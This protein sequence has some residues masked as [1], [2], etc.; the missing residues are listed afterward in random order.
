LRSE[1]DGVRLF[2]PH[3][4]ETPFP[5]VLAPLTSLRF[6]L[7]LGVVLF[8][9]QLQWTLGPDAAGL[10]NRARL[11]VDAFF[12]LSGFILTHV[13]LQGETAPSYFACLGARVARVFPVHWAILGGL[14]L[15]IL[16]APMVGVGLEPD[17]FNA[18]DFFTTLILVQ[19]WFPTDGMALWNGPA[20]SLSAEWFAYLIFPAFAW[21]AL[22]LK[23]R[24]G[25]LLIAAAALF[26]A[27]DALYRAAFGIVLP[28]AEDNLGIL[29]ILPTFLYGV[30]LYY[31]GRRFD[32]GPRLSWLFAAVAAGVFAGLM[33]VNADDRLIVAAAG[34]LIL[35]LA[36]VARNET[37]GGWLAHPAAVFAGEISY[38]LYLVHIPVL[39]AWRNA[40]ERL[41]GLGRD[42]LMG[43]LELTA[44]LSVMLVASIGLHL[45]VERPGR[46]GLRRLFRTRAAASSEARLVHSDQGEPL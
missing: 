41:F 9:F 15:L 14:L 23:R 44:L 25:W 22:R 43:P 42:Y 34:P 16:G 38:A 7:A 19:A 46:R 37:G 26:V 3:A 29:R 28:R 13:Y 5:D 1:R 6:V 31:C 17:R 21:I 36:F 33:Q 39:M 40:V 12:I 4:R 18:R 8:H 2:E 45:L 20:W 24:P 35:A 30:G 27:L 10:L 32:P 11:G